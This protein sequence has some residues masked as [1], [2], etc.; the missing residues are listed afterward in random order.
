MNKPIVKIDYWMF[1][2]EKDLGE[3][4][5]GVTSFEEDLS[6][7]F[8]VFLSGRPTD[9]MGGGLYELTLIIFYNDWA[10]NILTFGLG[11]VT[12]TVTDEI[13]DK[14]RNNIAIPLIKRI[15]ALF[16]KNKDKKPE[17]DRVKLTFKDTSIF[18]YNVYPNGL[19]SNLEI[20]FDVLIS[21]FS[22]F[23]KDGHLPGYIYV[24]VFK[25]PEF[26]A[27]D[28]LIH[29]PYRTFQKVDET[30]SGLSMESYFS[31]WGLYYSQLEGDNYSVYDVK[32]RKTRSIQ[33]A[34]DSF[35]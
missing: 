20:I 25:N 24:P 21:R 14:L 31:F 6:K 2:T 9:A 1:P 33:F 15:K 10:R 28:A 29:P 19:L 34:F 32:T 4:F 35:E 26:D 13:K 23:I 22:E 7:D 17:L 18:I 11:M 8:N 3:D 30:L 5:E 12:E 16:S 27:D